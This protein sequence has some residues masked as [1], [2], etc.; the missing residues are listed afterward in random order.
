[1]ALASLFG[2]DWMLEKKEK[3][4]PQKTGKVVNGLVSSLTRYRLVSSEGRKTQSAGKSCWKAST[5]YIVPL[6]YLAY[7]AACLW[8]NDAVACGD[9]P[10][11]KAED[12]LCCYTA[13]LPSADLHA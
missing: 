9:V 4:N 6:V 13:E 11:G 8:E 12:V 10:V 2:A 5:V 1:M 3:N 7:R